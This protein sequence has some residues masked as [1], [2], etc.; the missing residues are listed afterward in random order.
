MD[1]EKKRM[2]DRIQARE[3]LYNR[4]LG[5]EKGVTCLKC[6]KGYLESNAS[7]THLWCNNPKCNVSVFFYTKETARALQ[8]ALDSAKS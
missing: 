7:K 2:L 5:G 1:G 8:Q 3:K 4:V 6:G